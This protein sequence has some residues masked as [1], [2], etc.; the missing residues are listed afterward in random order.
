MLTISSGVLIIEIN[1]TVVCTLL[2]I[3]ISINF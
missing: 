2:F 1:P 3:V